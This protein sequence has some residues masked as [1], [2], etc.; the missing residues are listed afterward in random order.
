MY[1]DLNERREMNPA[2][3]HDRGIIGEEVAE[4][5]DNPVKQLG[6]PRNSICGRTTKRESEVEESFV[7]I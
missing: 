2:E 5:E 1:T 3:K 4:L 7:E 6:K